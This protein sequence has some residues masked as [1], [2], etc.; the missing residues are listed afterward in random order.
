MVV[1]CCH[2]SHPPKAHFI[3]QQAAA[4]LVAVQAHEALIHK[5]HTLALVG[6]QVAAHIGVHN[7]YS[8]TAAARQQ[9]GCYSAGCSLWCVLCR[10]RKDK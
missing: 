10:M 4:V 1:L 6:T 9:G 8:Q 7:L 3:C 5:C 2:P